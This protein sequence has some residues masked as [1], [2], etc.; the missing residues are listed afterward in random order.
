MVVV[1][2]SVSWKHLIDFSPEKQTK[3]I[4]IMD[5]P[6]LE[7]RREAERKRLKQYH[8]AC[9][10]SVVRS[11]YRQ[12]QDESCKS[13]NRVYAY[14][15]G[16]VAAFLSAVCM[17]GDITLSEKEIAGMVM[18]GDPLPDHCIRWWEVKHFP[19]D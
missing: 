5:I 12:T 6:T 10:A 18:A 17:Y 9:A 14:N 16:Y 15:L 19:D 7:E 8:R 11:A 2:I 3:V 4:V 13:N 1:F